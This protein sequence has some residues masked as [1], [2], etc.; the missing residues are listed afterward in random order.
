MRPWDS[1]TGTRCTRCVPPSNLNT[2]YAPSPLTANVYSPS[3]S[4]ERLGLEAA[5][6]GVLR[7]HPVEVARPDAGLVAAGA[8]ADLDD[9]VLVVV[10]VALDHREADLLLE[11]LDAR[12]GGREHLADLGVVVALVEQLARARRVVDARGATRR[13]AWPPAAAG[14]TARPTL[15]VALAVADH[16][17]VDDLALELREAR[18]DLL[19]ERLDHPVEA[20]G[21][22]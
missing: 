6:L 10:R 3:R 17:G 7:E 14:G 4:V 13:R 20:S 15:G 12:L 5:A 18:L 11:L 2:E 21:P 1:V 8:A 22:P 9:D 19:D 16:R